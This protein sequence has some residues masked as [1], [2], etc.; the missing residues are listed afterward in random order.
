MNKKLLALAALLI[1]AGLAVWLWPI[2]TAVRCP[3]ARVEL[4]EIAEYVD[5]EA[6]TRVERSY[7]IT[8]PIAGRVEEINFAPG[9][10]IREG[11]VLA[12]LVS[13][14]LDNRL[15]ELSAM[16]ERLTASIAEAEFV[17]VEQAE[18]DQSLKMV[19]MMREVEAA[20]K[21]QVAVRSSELAF[22]GSH[23][24]RILEL[25]N[26]SAEEELESAR[27]QRD[28]KEAEYQRDLHDH[29]ASVEG[30]DV[31]AYRAVR[32]Q[33]EI[34]R[35]RLYAVSLKHAREEAETR[36]RQ[37][38]LDHERSRMK[39]PVDGIVL[40]RYVTDE[41]VLPAGA[42]LLE[43]ARLADLEVVAE[44][45]TQDAAKIRPGAKVEIYGP[46]LGDETVIGSVR[47]IEPRA[48][49]KLSSLGVEEQRVNVII[50]FQAGTAERLYASHS[51]GVGFRVRV[52]IHVAE[53]SET[54]VV[55]RFA[56]FR[57][58]DANWQAYVVR[59]G[60]AMLQPVR[61]G[62]LNDDA[63]EI[64][65]GAKPG[66]VVLLAPDSSVRSGTRVQPAFAAPRSSGT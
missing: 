32:F 50:A 64:L 17:G 62:L 31:A 66:D 30:I 13:E 45:L 11:Q 3:A 28:A 7:K 35:R 16:V 43:V 47:R 41:R 2:W 38:R 26:I 19:D 22:A 36:L 15:A 44:V 53:R 9:T 14:D 24:E 65:E 57:G 46:S 4:G 42:E 8:M 39:S 29:L 48:Y 33:K 34:E 12:Q 10:P 60:V 56:I 37:A 27:S 55:P 58:P 5:I 6:K 49:T 21:S 52:R 59:S 54:N 18:V 40:E 63:A 1:G 23:L 25:K 20:R 61:V 51:L